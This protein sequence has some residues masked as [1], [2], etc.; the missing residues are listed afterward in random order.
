MNY[1]RTAAVMSMVGWMVGLGDR[2]CENILLDTT[3][4]D[5]IHVD[6]NCLFNKGDIFQIPEIVPFRLTHNMVDGMGILGIEGTFRQTCEKVTHLM[7]QHKDLLLSVLETFVYDPLLEWKRVTQNTEQLPPQVLAARQA[8][9]RAEA[10]RCKFEGETVNL[11]A[12]SEIENIR[13]RLNGHVG[14]LHDTNTQTQTSKM[15]SPMS[16]DG[17]VD[18]LIKEA[19]NSFSL[20]QMFIGWA[21][22]M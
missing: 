2:H 6:Y 14:K 1:C 13:W 18:L 20:A 3:N 8:A 11:T 15:S 9:A 4:G 16:V 22:Y 10:I 7:R 17:Q 21:S 5:C 12:K 19:T